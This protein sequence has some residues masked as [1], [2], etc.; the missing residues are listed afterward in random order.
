SFWKLNNNLSIIHQEKYL[1]YLPH[2]GF[3]NQRMELEYAIFLAWYL[4]RTL[5]IPHLLLFKGAAPI[6]SKSYDSMYKD[7]NV[8]ITSGKLRKKKVTYTKWNW[9]ELM[10]F[11]FVKQNIKYIH[12]QDFNFTQLIESLHINNNAEVYKIIN[13]RQQ[14]YYDDPTSTTEL[15]YLQERV[16]LIDLKNRNEK[17]LHFGSLFAEV[18]IIAQL[19]EN[20]KF[21]SQLKHKMLINNLMIINIVN[22]IIDKIG[23]TD[24][25][26]GAHARIGDSR[27]E[28]N[29]NQTVQKLIKSL[30]EDFKHIKEKNNSSC[31]PTKIFLATDVQKNDTSIRPFF[32][33]FPCIY[34]LSDFNDLLEPLKSLKNPMD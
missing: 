30:Q 19:P 23:G 12:R 22:D 13:S 21:W 28:I 29:K 26:I 34:V 2:S 6:T 10:D 31:S 3:N 14:Q 11:T 1:T 16:N 5:I 25:F 15:G 20:Q 24:N 18:K 7:L 8:L 33:T 27:F 4:N 9:E 17:L 32:Q